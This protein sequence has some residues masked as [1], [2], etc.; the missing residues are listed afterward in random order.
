MWCTSNKCLGFEWSA[1]HGISCRSIL[2][3]TSF[4][5]AAFFIGFV[6]RD[7]V[8][9]NTLYIQMKFCYLRKHQLHNF[10]CLERYCAIIYPNNNEQSHSSMQQRNQGLLMYCPTTW[11]MHQQTHRKCHPWNRIIK[12]NAWNTK[13]NR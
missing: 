11:V 4:I 2:I 10:L 6:W 8:T 9:Y 7:F 3:E 1:P 13:P 5:L 12:A